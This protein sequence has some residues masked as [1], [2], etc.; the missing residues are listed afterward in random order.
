MRIDKRLNLVVPIYAEEEG[1]DIV[2]W[3]HSTP[4]GEETVDRYFMVIAQTYAAIFSQGLG[5]AGGPAVAMRLLRHIA[6]ERGV[7]HDDPKTNSIGVENGVVEEIRRLTMVAAIKDGKWEQI[8]LAVA[9]DRG[10]VSAEDKTE[11]ENA[12]VFFIVASAVLPRAQ[13]PAMI[14]AAADLWGAQTSSFTITEWAASLKTSTGTATT[15]AK[16]PAGAKEKPERA[17]ATV[18]GKPLSVPV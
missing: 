13:R 10:I 7:W 1:G 8:P 18:A 9:V 6:T 17:N 5:L 16:Y 4:L 12:I 14:K 2:A 15:G 3:V 11:V